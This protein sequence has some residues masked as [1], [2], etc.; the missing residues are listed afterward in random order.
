MGAGLAHSLPLKVK[1][2]RLQHLWQPAILKSPSNSTFKTVSELFF[3]EDTI[4]QQRDHFT[5]ALQQS[6]NEQKRLDVHRNS[7]SKLLSTHNLCHLPEASTCIVSSSFEELLQQGPDLLGSL[8]TR[9]S[10]WS[11]G[12]VSS[13]MPRHAREPWCTTSRMHWASGGWLTIYPIVTSGMKSMVTDKV[14]FSG[15]NYQENGDEQSLGR[16]TAGFI[17]SVVHYYNLVLSSQ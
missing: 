2:Q 6:V 12:T 13:I 5:W 17:R 8:F 16:G 14:K 1:Y 7:E 11:S 9:C 15:I 10:I 3:N 4:L